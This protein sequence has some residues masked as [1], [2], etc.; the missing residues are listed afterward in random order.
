MISWF[1]KNYDE[2]TKDELYHIIQFRIGIFMI[3]QN[4]I[5]ED[6]DGLDQKAVHFIYPFHFK[7]L[8]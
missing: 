2:L 1:Q 3:E 7:N 4:S 5:Y 8:S 6:L